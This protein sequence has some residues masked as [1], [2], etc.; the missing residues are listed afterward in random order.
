MADIVKPEVR[1]RMMSRIRGRNTK[2]EISLR[3][4]LHRRG[5]RYRLNVR[6]LP[7]SPDIVFPKWKTVLFV[8]GCY[9]HRHP[10]CPKTTTPSSNAEFW[11]DKFEQNVERDKRNVDDL[12]SSGWRVGIV[13]E[14]VIGHDP[15]ESLLD[16]IEV[17]LHGD[18]GRPQEFE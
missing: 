9:W 6:N 8:H 10:G 11:A 18:D 17:F 4:A 5:L 3:K 2:P 12:L 1:S 7:G 16:K 15:T 14:C 13:W